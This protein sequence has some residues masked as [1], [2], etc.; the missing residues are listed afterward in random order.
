M[1]ATVDITDVFEDAVKITAAELDPAKHGLFGAHGQRY[2]LDEVFV[3][4]K[5]IRSRTKHGW[6]DYWQPTDILTVWPVSP[7]AP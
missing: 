5:W 4:K 6:V 1:S 2:E 7:P 3:G